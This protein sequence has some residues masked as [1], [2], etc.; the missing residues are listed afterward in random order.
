MNQDNEI[1]VKAVQAA[2]LAID[3]AKLMVGGNLILK[4]AAAYTYSYSHTIDLGQGRTRTVHLAFALNQ[5][6][7]QLE[8]TSQS[9]SDSDG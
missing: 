3:L 1:V 5:V 4:S 8:L 9:F 6:S 2:E 7:G